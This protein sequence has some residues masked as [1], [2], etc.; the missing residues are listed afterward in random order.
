MQLSARDQVVRVSMALRGL[1]PTPD[2]LQ[3][4]VQGPEALRTLAEEWSRSDAFGA[5]VRDLYAEQLLVREDH[6]A[7]QQI[8]NIL[9]LQGRVSSD[10]MTSMNDEPLRLIEH[11]VLEDLPFTEVVQADWMLADEILAFVWGLPFDDEGP[12]WQRSR[13]S[14]GRPHAGVLSSSAVFRRHESAGSN[15][16]RGRA[17]HLASVFLC[18][19]LGRRELQIVD[20][21][22]LNDELAV[23][24]A[25]QTDAGCLGCHATLEPFATFFW[26]FP[27]RLKGEAI[28]LAYAAG[29]QWDPLLDEPVSEGLDPQNYCYP[30]RLFTPAQQDD[31]TD[32][33]LPPP[34]YYGQPGRDLQ[35]L[36]RMMAEDPRFTQCAVRRFTSYLTQTAPGDVP[37]ETIDRLASSFVASGHNAR[38]LAVDIVTDRAFLALAATDDRGEPA[39][40][41]G[42][43]VVRPEQYD[44]L[45]HQ[46]TGFHWALQ[47]GNGNGCEP[48]CWG[49]VNMATTDLYG[50]R[51]LMGGIDGR[52]V[53]VPSHAASPTKLMAME[54]MAFETA[55]IAGQELLT[56]VDPARADDPARREQLAALV[57]HLLSIEPDDALL[58]ELDALFHT[59]ATRRDARA[60][61]TVVIAA[62]L[63]DP[64]VVFY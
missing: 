19:D 12:D 36:G 16:H 39:R 14:D 52:Q 3:R 24:H 5:T 61:W 2:E 64:R 1:R 31:Y 7:Y 32:F 42:L 8:P 49:S 34:A 48:K 60:G 47:A 58:E 21:V 29:C 50:F 4:G 30:L 27:R 53:I 15:F 54:R 10:V 40:V 44:R 18:D 22:D 41:A 26:G 28:T 51:T 33:D 37:F 57:R 9:G 25:V 43:Q 59:A 35:D 38:Q 17:S 46:L 11:V 63:Q 56:L 45:V 62:L 6:V 13:W 20:T 55:A 23:A